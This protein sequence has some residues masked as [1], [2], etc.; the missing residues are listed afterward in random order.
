MS[1][2]SNKLLELLSIERKWN[3]NYLRIKIS[4]NDSIE[5]LWEIDEETASHLENAISFEKNYQYSLSFNSTWDVIKKQHMSFFIK[6]HEGKSENFYFICSEQYAEQL[7]MMKNSKMITQLQNLSFL[8]VEHLDKETAVTVTPKRSFRKPIF[9]SAAAF[10]ILLMIVLVYSSFS[11]SKNKSIAQETH[12]TAQNAK[13]E[14]KPNVQVKSNIGD[15][16]AFKLADPITYH[17]EEDSVALTFDDGPSKYSTEIIDILKKYKVGGTFFLIGQNVK[18]YPDH[19]QYIYSHGFSIGNHSMHH[20]NFQKLSYEKQKNEIF[21]ANKLIED[22]TGEPV[23]LFRPPYGEK[24]DATLQ[25]L[26]ENNQKIVMWNKDTEDWKTHSPEK[27]IYY[28][29]HSNISGSIILLHESKA[30][31]DALPTIIEELQ[32]QNLRIVNLK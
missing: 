12:V 6:T 16:P 13:T 19:V 26:D 23:S 3:Q 30:V 7:K 20:A 28:I 25:L 31:V 21:E 8:H 17:I 15:A 1:A 2:Y 5:L 4:L 9:V 18:K 29:Q 27:I 22:I 14:R 11:F 10:F 24:N 32:K